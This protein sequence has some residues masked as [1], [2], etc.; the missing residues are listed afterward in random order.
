MQTLSDIRALL[1]ARGIRPKHRYG[2][3]FLH[4]KNQLAKLVDAAGITAGD[5]VLEVGPG[6]GTLTEALL[7]VGVSVVACE[8]DRDMID[9]LRDRLGDRIT[10]IEGDVLERGRQLREDLVRHIDGR[11]FRLVANLPYQVASPLMGALL[12]DHPNCLGQF[13]T[14]QREVADRLLS[15]PGMKTYGPLTI[16]AQ[17]FARVERLA[18]VKP[19]SFWP[20][21]KVTSAMIALFPHDEHGIDDPHDFAR[22]IVNLFTARRKQLGSVFGRDHDQ[23]WWPEGVAATTRPDALTIEQARALWERV[24]SAEADNM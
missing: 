3:N 21:P 8:I 15:P 11:P 12:L 23:D 20:I 9:I 14:I 10:L 4:D 16:I 13:V 1:T 17:T 2:Q 6:T 19:A 22:F 7:D 5:L 18:I 24:R